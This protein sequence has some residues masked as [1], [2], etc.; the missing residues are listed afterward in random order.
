MYVCIVYVCIHL[1]KHT[2]IHQYICTLGY[3]IWIFWHYGASGRWWLTIF[4]MGINKCRIS[5]WCQILWKSSIKI[6]TKKLSAKQINEHEIKQKSAYFHRV[7]VN[8][9]FI[10]NFFQLFQRIQNQHHKFCW[11][12]LKLFANFEVKCKARTEKRVYYCVLEFNLTT[13]V[14]ENQVVEIIVP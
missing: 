12:I 7:F 2:N 9:L 4:K 8:N 14:W 11:I 13:M 10:W 6:H 5:G 3:N 1:Y